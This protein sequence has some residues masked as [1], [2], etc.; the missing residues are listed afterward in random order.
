MTDLHVKR[1]YDDEYLNPA[2]GFRVFVDRLWP[3]GESKSRF[4]FNLWAKDIAPSEELREWFHESP[5]E[6]WTEF[7]E[8]YSKELA[9]NA[10][11]ARMISLLGKHTDVTLLYG[12]RQTQHNNA[13]A[14]AEYLSTQPGFSFTS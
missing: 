3:R 12:S 2:D 6:R 10:E 4:K 9:A 13:V 1:L 7:K 5:D 11:T 8:R 14:L